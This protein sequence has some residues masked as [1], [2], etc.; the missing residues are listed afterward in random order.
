MSGAA[1][2]TLGAN[3]TVDQGRLISESAVTI[4][5]GGTHTIAVPGGVALSSI[6]I[7]TPATKL[8]YTVGDS[9]NTTG[10][11]VTATYTDVSTR[12]VTPDSITG[13]D[14]SHTAT[15]Q[16]L[17]IHVGASTTAYAINVL[18]GPPSPPLATVNLGNASSYVILSGPTPGTITNDAT[19][20]VISGNAGYN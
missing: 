13:F 9:L 18:A 1:A 2:I 14:S 10:L 7:T 16:V 5:D 3:S 6:T 15:N 11:V 8:S 17:T 20:Q 4:L 12:I 19:A